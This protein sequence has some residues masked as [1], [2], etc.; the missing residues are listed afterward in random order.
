[1]KIFKLFYACRKTQANEITE[2]NMCIRKVC[3]ASRRIISSFI[4]T[5]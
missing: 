1:M 5:K 4:K 2:F 3:I